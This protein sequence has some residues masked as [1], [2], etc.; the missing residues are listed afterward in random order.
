MNQIIF[1]HAIL[2]AIVVDHRT[3]AGHVLKLIFGFPHSFS[4]L[5]EF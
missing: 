5:N 2:L 3:A 4:N 1:V